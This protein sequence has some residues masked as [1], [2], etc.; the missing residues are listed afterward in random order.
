MRTVVKRV[1]NPALFNL[2]LYKDTNFLKSMEKVFILTRQWRLR[3]GTARALAATS[4]P[5]IF[6]Y[7][8]CLYLYD[9]VIE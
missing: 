9:P 1:S 5:W 8:A 3:I 7:N 4:L 6:G 2:P